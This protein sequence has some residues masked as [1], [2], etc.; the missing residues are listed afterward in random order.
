M[1]TGEQLL[2]VF[3][4]YNQ[5]IWPM[6]IAAYLLGIT[7]LYLASR[8]NAISDR[9][10]PAI[11]AFLWLWVGFF[12]WLPS[13]GQGFVPG[14]L[15]TVLFLFQ[16]MLFLFFTLRA[17]LSFGLSN[18][19]WT[20]TGVFFVA[21][22]LVGYP[23]VGILLGRDTTSIPSFGLTP[24]PLVTFTFGMLLLVR[25]EITQYAL[26]IPFIYA[27]SGFL[28]V[29]IGIVE[30]VGLIAS[31]LA[32]V[33]LIWY[34]GLKTKRTAADKDPRASKGGWSLDLTDKE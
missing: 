1:I 4:E 17:K 29:S 32:A 11:L 13:A 5:Q 9:F 24:C 19:I 31:G 10:I 16:G 26:I 34:G 14:Y 15:F 30:D 23:L 6:Q 3:A 28:W 33:L 25:R 21:Y 22:A 8:K 12:F 2:E 18:D 7:G 27:L 20:W